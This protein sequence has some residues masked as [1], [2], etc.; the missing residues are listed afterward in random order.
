MPNAFPY[1]GQRLSVIERAED[2]TR[3]GEITLEPKN[4]FAQ[5]LDH[6]ADCVIHDR[7][8]LT[9]G[10]EG[11]QDHKLMEAI[12]ES[13]RTGQPVKLPAVQGLDHFRGQPVKQA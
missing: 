3:K 6:M 12:Y 4:Q 8:P 13:A 10:E 5:E 2:A 9:P 7:E 1:Q 11:V